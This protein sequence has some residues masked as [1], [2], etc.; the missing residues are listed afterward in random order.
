[1]NTECGIGGMRNL[2]CFWLK[3]FVL[4]RIFCDSIFCDRI[5]RIFRI[6]RINRILVRMYVFISQIL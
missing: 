3:E 1:M 4:D 6:N 5:N 2:R